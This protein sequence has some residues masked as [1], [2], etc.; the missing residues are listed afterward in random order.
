MV[1]VHLFMQGENEPF[2]HYVSAVAPRIHETIAMVGKVGF[3]SYEVLNVIHWVQE[4][5]DVTRLTEV[6]AIVRLGDL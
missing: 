5:H 2:T 6:H 1:Q 4:D 3:T